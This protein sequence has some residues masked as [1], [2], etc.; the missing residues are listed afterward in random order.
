MVAG[1][2][3]GVAP[4]IGF[5]LIFGFLVVAFSVYQ[6]V[7]IP[8]QNKQAEF[9]HNERTQG[10]LLNLQDSIR[11]TGTTGVSQSVSIQV[12]ADYPDR[13][14][15]VN[16]AVTGGRVSTV[17]PNP[18]GPNDVTF[19]NVR[20]IRPEARDY[21]NSSDPNSTL[22][23]STKDIVYRPTYTRYNDAPDTVFSNTGVFNQFDDANLSIADQIMIQG[24]R[25]TIVAINGSLDRSRTGEG[26]SVSVDTEP[27]SVATRSVVVENNDS[28]PITITV[29]TTVASEDAWNASSLEDQRGV[30]DIEVT[31]HGLAITLTNGTY[32]LRMAKVGVGSG[33]E[34]EGAEYIVP[35]DPP[36]R[37][38]FADTSHE[39]T[40]E[41]RDRFNNPNSDTVIDAT[42]DGEG[43]IEPLT[44]NNETDSRGRVTFNYTAPSGEADDTLVFNISGGP[45]GSADDRE[46]VTHSVTV[47]RNDG[48]PPESSDARRQPDVLGVSPS[49]AASE[50][51]Y[52]AIVRVNPP[53]E[54][55]IPARNQIPK[56][57][58]TWGT[59]RNT[60]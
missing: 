60:A 23:F 19:E 49:I 44:G 18:N 30:D 7:I 34:E 58:M 3:R 10:E 54:R 20:A 25:I 13:A 31:G 32:S 52:L 28:G 11:R 53:G 38:V 2:D 41:A 47:V 5:I 42:V 57:S 24:D 14:L 56:K 22:A 59:A 21:W 1:E 4:V 6:G 37:T 36:P 43:S 46:I 45:A 40:V 48:D 39:I 29:P 9:Q 50:S 51:N 15:G 55:E 33:T 8:D 26:A 27:L 16:F 17:K 12:G 35:V